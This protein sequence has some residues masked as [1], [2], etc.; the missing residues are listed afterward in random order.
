MR[1]H[2]LKTL[3]ILEQFIHGSDASPDLEEAFKKVRLALEAT[4]SF[5]EIKDI[6]D[7]SETLRSHAKRVKW[8]LEIQ[9]Q[10]AEI[11]LRAERKAGIILTTFTVKGGNVITPMMVVVN[12]IAS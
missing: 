4:N 5:E 9:N 8:S 3:Y 12:G 10:C 7:Q 2:L 11:K 6:R 1:F